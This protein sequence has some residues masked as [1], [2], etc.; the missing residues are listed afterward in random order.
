[1]YYT[2]Y[3]YIYV[4][5]IK[6]TT[7]QNYKI[8]SMT[9]IS[10]DYK[11]IYLYG[12]IKIHKPEHSLHQIISKMP[13]PIYELKKTTIK[14]LITPYSPRKYNIQSTDELIQVIHTIKSNNGILALLDVENLFTNVPINETVDI[15][16]KIIYNNP[17]LPPLKINPN[18]LQKLLLTWTTE[19]LF[20]DDLANIY[21]QTDGVSM[22]SVLDPIFS[23]FY[24]SDLENKILIAI[25]NSQYAEDMLMISLFLLMILTNSTYN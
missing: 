2:L 6:H 13:T 3:I 4:Y 7:N 20:H 18:I 22:G 5:K 14:Q 23:N 17:S 21:V 8:F 24:M 19:V 11:A 16:I 10:S 9:K 25:E 12:T 15:I 1:M